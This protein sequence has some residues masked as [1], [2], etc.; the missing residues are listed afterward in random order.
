MNVF[1][2]GSLTK[3]A[4]LSWIDSKDTRD[5]QNTWKIISQ[6]SIPGVIGQNSSLLWQVCIMN[7]DG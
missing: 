5:L 2:H 7:K 3:Q 4:R 1:R 6:L